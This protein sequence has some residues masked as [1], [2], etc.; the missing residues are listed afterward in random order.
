[1]NRFSTVVLVPAILSLASGC[2]SSDSSEP[3]SYCN[4]RAALRAGAPS[5]ADLRNRAYVVSEH[6]G[7][8]AAID[9]RSMELLGIADPCGEAAGGYHM[10]E[11]NAD[12]TKAYATDGEANQVDVFDTTTLT[13]AGHIALAGHPA[14]LSLSPDG[15]YLAVVAEGDNAVAF[16]D[17]AEDV[18]VKRLRGFFTPHFVRFTRDGRHAYVANIGAHHITRVDMETLEVE[19]HIALDGFEGP[20]NE[21][22]TVEEG[23]FADVQIDADGILWAAHRD[24]GKAIVYDTN[25]LSKLP[26]VGVGQRPWVIYAEHPFDNVRARTVPNWGDRNVAVVE[27]DSV[28]TIMTEESESFGVNYSSVAPDKAFVMNRLRE[29]IAVVNTRTMTREATIP[30]EGNTET[31]A[32][33]ADGK[34]IVAAVSGADSVVVLE[35]ES[36]AIVTTFTEVGEYPWSVTIPLGQNYCH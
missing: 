17:T 27:R 31:A 32:T 22:L 5:A 2:G 4:L 30:V 7:D 25:T 12:F 14:H 29:E 28:S 13:L 20:P 8:V 16:I 35:A 18:E 23:G 24:T 1:M 9:L 34:Y 26:E 36:N 3:G 15:Q 19:E 6:S 21:T 11:L 10:L 33:T